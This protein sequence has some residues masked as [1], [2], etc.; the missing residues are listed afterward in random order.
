M[1]PDRNTRPSTWD[2]RTGAWLRAWLETGATKTGAEYS[3][4]NDQEGRPRLS[5]FTVAAQAKRRSTVDITPRYAL[6][7]FGQQFV[8]NGAAGL[9]Q[10]VNWNLVAPQLHCIPE[11]RLRQIGD[12]DS[13]H[14]H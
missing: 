14:V 5:A 1:A 2:S 9:C 6:G 11:H 12:V 13:E 8:A 3:T 10:F 7:N 4:K